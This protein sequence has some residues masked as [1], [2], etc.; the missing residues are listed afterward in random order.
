MLIWGL[1]ILTITWKKHKRVS[2][3][4]VEVTDIA[5]GS[6][7]QKVL[8]GERCKEWCSRTHSLA[9]KQVPAVLDAAALPTAQILL[10]SG[11]HGS[12]TCWAVY[13]FPTSLLILPVRK[14]GA[15]LVAEID[16]HR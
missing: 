10:F 3:Y 12:P 4:S 15:S 14:I 1:R 9:H 2:G 8:S 11:L 6:F 5:P 16:S 7:Q 13:V